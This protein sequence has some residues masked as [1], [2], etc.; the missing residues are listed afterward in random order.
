MYKCRGPKIAKMDA[1]IPSNAAGIMKIAENFN[2]FE[3]DWRKAQ[4]RLKSSLL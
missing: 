1:G 4:E 2:V 3:I